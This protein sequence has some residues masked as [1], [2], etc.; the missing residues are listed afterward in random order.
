MF[1][2]L[3]AISVRWEV[4]DNRTIVP[5]ARE[6]L[7]AF[8]PAVL[9][10]MDAKVEESASGLEL[11]AY[12]DILKAL[13][14]QD[15]A[16]VAGFLGTNLASDVPRRKKIG[17]HLVG[18]LKAT[19]LEAGV[20][21]ILAGEDEGLQRRAAGVAFVNLAQ[22]GDDNFPGFTEMLLAVCAAV[23]TCGQVCM[24]MRIR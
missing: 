21:A 2:E 17:L 1:D 12:V 10:M 22:A 9:P 19:G 24:S 14:E 13:G 18:E 20:V 5:K 16:A 11:R 15:A 8:G 4:G 7:I 3:W 23:A 6:R